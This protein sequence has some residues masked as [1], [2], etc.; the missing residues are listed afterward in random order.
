MKQI[1]LNPDLMKFIDKVGV[2]HETVGLPRIG[3]RILGLMIIAR[4]PISPDEIAST[5]KVSRSSVSTNLKGLKLF[6]LIEEIRIPGNR[7]EFYQ[8]SEHAFE[9]MIKMR[10]TTYDPF[11]EILTEGLATLKK[12]KLPTGHIQNLMNY[13]TLEKN[14]YINLLKKIEKKGTG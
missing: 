10:L 5:L 14:L 12:N 4:E 13:N 8:F 3:G 2:F 6:R 9:N 1:G 7:K 11:T